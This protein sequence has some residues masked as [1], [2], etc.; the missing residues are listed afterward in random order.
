MQFLILGGTRFLG[1]HFAAAALA[2]GHS[3]TLVCRGRSV[4]PFA[5]RVTVVATDR[6]PAAGGGPAALDAAGVAPPEG[7]D[8]VIDFSGYV[9]RVVGAWARS[10]APRARRYL[11]VS[12]IS[13]YESFTRPLQN[14]SSPLAR[15]ADPASEDI[16]AHYGALK[17]ACENE[18]HA[19]FG[20]GA[21]IVRPGLIVGP[22]DP[23]DRFPY[24]AARFGA[25]ELLG[26]RGPAV[27]LPAPLTLAVQLIDAR[28]LAAWM[29]S[30]LEREDGDGSGVY[31]ATSPAGRSSFEDLWS[32]GRALAGERGLAL[33]PCPI[34][35]EALEAAGVVPWTGL[36]LWLGAGDPLFKE[37]Q[38]VDC[39]AAEALGLHCRP[40]FESLR[41]T[42]SW[43]LTEKPAGRFGG[44]MTDADERALAAAQALGASG[45]PVPQ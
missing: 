6:D 21:L 40:L 19:A 17:A 23:T 39:S 36:P 44:V 24:W 28:D 34:A 5:G 37:M 27:V 35:E 43:L 4:N 30:L 33:T 13:V 18:V 26:G 15:L 12:S 41:D 8:A 3:L 14:E 16:A 45:A 32:S 2:R 1:R 11:F 9:P 38:R 20:R 42:L 25:P 10:L 22:F 29:L 31:N 7:W